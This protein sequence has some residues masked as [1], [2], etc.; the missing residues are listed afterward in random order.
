MADLRNGGPL[1]PVHANI[2]CRPRR[3]YA[4]VKLCCN[5]DADTGE[6]TVF[7][8]SPDSDKPAQ[9]QRTD[10]K[11][12]HSDHCVLTVSAQ[13]AGL[14]SLHIRFNDANVPGKHVRNCTPGV[15]TKKHLVIN[16]KNSNNI[17]QEAKGIWRRLHG[18]TPRT[19]HAVYTARAA[20]DSSRVTDRLTDRH[21]AHR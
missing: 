11:T 19:Q 2:K 8:D 9:C 5:D 20:A 10:R 12:D 4:Y 3:L 16:F 21:R 7:C 6:L 1:P 13:C 15:L 18:M 17:K 14:H